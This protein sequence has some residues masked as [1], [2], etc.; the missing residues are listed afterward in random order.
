MIN[1]QDFAEHLEP[2]CIHGNATFIAQ[3]ATL[4]ELPLTYET[5]VGKL[6]D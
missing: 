6:K 3:E 2:L 1:E 4:K 5:P